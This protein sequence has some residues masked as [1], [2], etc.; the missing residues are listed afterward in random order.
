MN[1]PF[2]IY[3][4]AFISEYND[5]PLYLQEVSRLSD[6]IGELNFELEN[7]D[8]LSKDFLLSFI[9]GSTMEDALILSNTSQANLFQFQQLFPNYIIDKINFENDHNN[10]QNI[11]NINNI[12][13]NDETLTQIKFIQVIIVSPD[14]ILSDSNY[15]PLFTEFI[16]IDFKKKKSI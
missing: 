16:G 8:I 6:F 11:D 4:H 15:K 14:K 3:P 13:N 7:N 5:Y 12:D 10:I 1:H 9:I 2:Y